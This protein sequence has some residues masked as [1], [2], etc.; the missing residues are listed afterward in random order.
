MTIE[1]QSEKR[2]KGRCHIKYILL[3]HPTSIISR[4]IL[5]NKRIIY[6]H[7]LHPNEVIK[8]KYRIQNHVKRKLQQDTMNF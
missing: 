6:L 4:Y 5:E 3:I 2:N 7:D 8:D 1:A